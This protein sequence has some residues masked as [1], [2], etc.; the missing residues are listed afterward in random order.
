VG[1]TGVVPFMRP[2]LLCPLLVTAA[3]VAGCGSSSSS[4]S[5]SAAPAASASSSTSSSTTAAASSGGGYGGYGNKSAAATSAAAVTVTTKS[6]KLGTILAAG[7]KQL[8]VYLFEGDKGMSS[9]CSGP[10]A[11]V[12]PPVSGKPA[13]AGK[14]Q[15]GNLGTVKRSDGST[16]VTYKGHPLY[17]FAKDKD[18]GDAYGQGIN[19]FGASWYVLAPS[20][21]KVDKS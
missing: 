13:P 5:S 15:A 1:L 12:W 4:S 9:T 11:S 10:C 19:G 16:Q 14:A 17:Y 3:V 2:L 8:T 7:P 6:N 20:G 21:T 18:G